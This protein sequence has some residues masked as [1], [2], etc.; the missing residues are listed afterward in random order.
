MQSIA[1][2]EQVMKELGPGDPM[3]LRC[4]EEGV[5]RLI[6][7]VKWSNEVKCFLITLADDTSIGIPALCCGAAIFTDHDMS[8]W[9]IEEIVERNWTELIE[10]RKEV[11]KSLLGQ[12]GDEPNPDLH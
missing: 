9:R 3:L 2:H 11:Q 5:P 8:L 1:I 4:D 7:N 10:G 6:Q 12:I